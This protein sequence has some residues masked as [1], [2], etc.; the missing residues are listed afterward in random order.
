MIPSSAIGCMR[1][2]AVLNAKGKLKQD[3]EFKCRTC[4]GEATD[5]V[6]EC[7][8][9]EINDQSLKVLELNQSLEAFK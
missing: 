5:T 6:Q 3:D 1:D 2:V 8:S 7:H 9:I 4:A